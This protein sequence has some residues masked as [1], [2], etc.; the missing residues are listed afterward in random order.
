MPLHQPYRLPLIPGAQ[1]AMQ[2]ARKAGASA[3]AL[4][5]AGPSLIAFSGQP[6]DAAHRPGHAAGLRA[7]RA[8]GAHLPTQYQPERRQRRRKGAS[9]LVGADLRVRP[10]IV[11]IHSSRGEPTSRWGTIYRTSRWGHEY[12]A[13]NPRLLGAGDG[14]GRSYT[15]P[16]T[17]SNPRL[18][19][20]TDL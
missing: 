3:V 2:A 18:P 7:G 15:C 5:G 1:D 12:R 17:C 14:R 4:S 10:M 11:S 13:H 19:G 8:D 9:R 20:G 16:F 6:A